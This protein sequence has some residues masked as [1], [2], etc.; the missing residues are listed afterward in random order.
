[1]GAT[2]REI[3]KDYWGYD[4]FRGPQESIISK[5]LAQEDILAILPTGGGKSLCFQVPAL[6]QPG[7]CL[8]ISPL[9]ALMIDQVERLKKL[10][11]KAAALHAGHDRKRLESILSDA[12]NGYLDILYL[13]PERL[14]S[15]RTMAYL[16]TMPINLLTVDE[17][18]CICE[19]GYDFRPA[20]LEISKF[21][22]L[23]PE[24]PIL[25]LTASATPLV[26]ADIQEKLRFKKSQ[27]MS[28]SLK[29]PNIGYHVIHTLDKEQKLREIC[30]KLKGT[31]IVY[32]NSRNGVER[33]AFHLKKAGIASDYYHAGLN[34]DDRVKRQRAWLKGR[35]RIIVATNAFGMGIDKPDVR[36]VI[37]IQLPLSLEA[38]YQESGRG[39]RDGKRAYAVL[40]YN[41]KDKLWLVDQF[42][43]T[44]PSEIDVRK[45]Y[46]CLALYTDQAVGS[47]PEFGF[48]F[49]FEDFV[50][51]YNLEKTKTYYCL[52][53]LMESGWISV[54]DQ[55]YQ[56]SKL[57]FIIDR[58]I[59]YDLQLKND[60]LDLITKSMLRNY[61]GLFTEYVSISERKLSSILRID[62]SEVSS[63]LTALGREG[64][65]DYTPAQNNP[66]LYLTKARVRSELLSLDKN[67]I[68]FRKQRHLSRI[69]KVVKYVDHTDCREQVIL[70]Y[71][72]QQVGE[73]CGHCD[74]CNKRRKDKNV[75][76]IDDL[77][78]YIKMY[79][80]ANLCSINQVMKGFKNYNQELLISQ[81]ELLQNENKIIIEGDQ[82][83]I[84]NHE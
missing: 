33:M 24:I 73:K 13:S 41:E 1:M 50:S 62:E 61:E 18:H 68:E 8:V 15:Q 80:V 17:A 57:K 11:V 72:G 3:L 65:V 51:K 28:S 9:I 2:P 52:K 12:V 64:I 26:Q 23:R 4:D 30:M 20:Y 74:L 49:S 35:L 71:F 63:Y 47:F 39:G 53:Q 56:P 42:K 84:L 55:I 59:L 34:M 46:K 48:D 16:Q 78:D 54:S 5:V 29:R 70:N 27:V 45:V 82:I 76:K 19:W 44:Y 21:R 36:F 10:G 14:I 6:I 60:K 32:L 58:N 40:L 37:H 25:A 22:E 31:G 7:I 83:A 38:Y 43:K 69:N 66:K 75:I 81:L 79:A 77:F 67:K